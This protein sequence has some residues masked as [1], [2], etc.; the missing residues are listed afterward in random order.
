MASPA[1]ADILFSNKI[2]NK[3]ITVPR[4]RGIG[5]TL[6]KALC[7]VEDQRQAFGSA[8]FINFR[9]VVFDNGHATVGSKQI[10]FDAFSG[11]DNYGGWV[12]EV[13]NI[14]GSSTVNISYVG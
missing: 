11:G 4:Q 6:A 8:L 7:V 12:R 1:T 2:L 14:S 10:G 13:A 5:A 3:N 9:K